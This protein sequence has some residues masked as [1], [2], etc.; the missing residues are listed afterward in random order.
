MRQNLQV[1]KNTATLRDLTVKAL[2]QAI[3]DQVLAPGERLVERDLCER[4]GVSRTCLREALQFLESE[5][6][7][8][9]STGKGLVV[10]K[11]GA[12]EAREL[13]EIRSALER[14]LGIGFAERADAEDRKALK[15]AA[16]AVGRSTSGG[17]QPNYITTLD[18]F[19]EI[20]A[21][22]ARNDMAHRMLNTLKSR[23]TYLRSLT[24]RHTTVEREQETARL[25][26]QIA[27]AAAKG[28]AVRTGALCEGFARRSA[29]FAIPL[30][31]YTG[32]DGGA[33]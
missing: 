30:L 29:E 7:V 26:Q 28:E 33:R 19:F 10:V 12:E 9:R 3:F 22:G 16:E 17:L 6:L 8:A 2:R 31:K 5:G 25:L 20:L 1:N 27:T 24:S 4:T 21:K 13:Y 23:I 14:L 18:E 15:N 11:I 32:S